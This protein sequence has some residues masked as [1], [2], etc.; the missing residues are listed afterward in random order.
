MQE[1]VHHETALD[2]DQQQIGRLYAKALLGASGDRVDE[3]V[4]ELEA[5]VSEC[6]DRNRNLE[7]TLSSPRIP[8]EQKEGLLDR[9]F[10]D[11]IDGALLNFLKI[12]CR[13]GRI[14]SLRAIQ[15][16]ATEMREQQLGRQ[17]VQVVSAQPLTDEQRAT[18]S[19][20]FK[21]AYGKDAVLIEKVDASLLG[22]I[23]LRVG[24]RVID[25]S[26]LGKLDSL[27]MSVASGIQKAI[28]DRYAELL[29]S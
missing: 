2:S 29:S 21:S 19:A 6:L 8:E 1:N 26:V 24:D 15:A 11:K 20:A 18:I 23:V 10:R 28:R 13:R 7:A 16:V 12:L 14:G 5:I 17:R 25:G 3:I 22:G 4:A 9:I 27:R